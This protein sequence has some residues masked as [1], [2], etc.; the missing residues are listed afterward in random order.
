LLAFIPIIG[1][2]ILIVFLASEGNQG[3]NE[4]GPPPAAA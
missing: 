4:Y 1:A 2:I 3:D